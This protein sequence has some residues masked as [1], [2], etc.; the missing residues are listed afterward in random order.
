M[1]N[2]YYLKKNIDKEYYE[3]GSIYAGIVWFR[4]MKKGQADNITIYG[5][6]MRSL[7]TAFTHLAEYKQGVD[8]LKNIR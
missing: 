5:H 3:S 8:F 6:H 7:G 4:L 2:N 1:G